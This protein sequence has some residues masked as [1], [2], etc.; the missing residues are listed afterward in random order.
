M[1]KFVF[2]ID[3]LFDCPRCSTFRVNSQIHIFL[4]DLARIESGKTGDRTR[5]RGG[6]VSHQKLEAADG[7]LPQHPLAFTDVG[8]EALH[9]VRTVGV[10]AVFVAG[11]AAAAAAAAADA[12]DAAA[13]A[14]HAAA[15]TVFARVAFVAF[16]WFIEI[17]PTQKK[18]RLSR[19][20]VAKETIS[21]FLK[22]GPFE[23]KNIGNEGID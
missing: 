21:F 9:A 8:R 23:G 19:L 7:V 16:D 18:N 5:I 2:V 12:A 20:S 17:S 4:F 13:A 1:P 22:N 6:R 10:V 11:I 14:A 15:A 3:P